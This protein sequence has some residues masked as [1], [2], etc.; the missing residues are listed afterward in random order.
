MSVFHRYLIVVAG[1]KGVRMGAALPKQFLLLAGRPVIFHTIARFTDYDPGIELIIVLPGGSESRWKELCSR[2]DFSRPH[3]IIS[4]GPERFD[5]VRNGLSLVRQ[6]SLVAVHDAVRP[7]V[8]PGTIDRCFTMAGKKGNAVPFVRPP[9]SI[10]E[11]V[12]EKNSRPLSR[13]TIAL[14]QTPQVFRS[15]ILLTAYA[16]SYSPSFTDDASVVEA[17]GHRI[18]LVEGNRENIKITTAED[19]L[20]AEAF[21]DHMDGRRE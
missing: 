8:S 1:G 15:D 21:F 9:E 5:S 19:L 4:G 18:N 10:R 16:R 14:I 17:A 3:H 7:L 11:T 12:S 13:D 2:Y 6:E 20:V